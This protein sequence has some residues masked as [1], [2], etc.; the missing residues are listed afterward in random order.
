MY[1]YSLL[2]NKLEDNKQE[3]IAFIVDLS[4]DILL[5][6][7]VN[8]NL[9]KVERFDLIF[10]GISNFVKLKNYF[11]STNTQFALY[12]YTNI[13]N[14]EIDFCDVRDFDMVFQQIF[15]TLKKNVCVN[16]G[17][18]NLRQ[19]SDMSNNSN[20]SNSNNEIKPLDLAHIFYESINQVNLQSIHKPEGNK[21]SIPDD[22]II[23]R[24][25]LIYNRSNMPVVNSNE[26][27]FNTMNFIR[28]TNF[29][30]DVI[31][32]RKKINAEEDKKI[33]NEVYTSLTSIKPKFW[34]ALEISTSVNK[35]NFSMNLLLA[36]AS[37]R[38]K[39]SELD[40]YQKKIEE[41]V[42]NYFEN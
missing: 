5:E 17:M 20:K 25:I 30:F 41:I 34:Y 19:N 2:P 6:D 37:Q 16:R 11:S 24:Y 12:S 40:K 14:K 36:N 8:P 26:K 10:E 32:L 7:F 42:R 22:R 15:S 1:E 33:L 29:C 39:V 38:I 3:K 21:D 9:D 35:F 31:F 18:T 23:Y 28:L 4:E 13:L 27:E